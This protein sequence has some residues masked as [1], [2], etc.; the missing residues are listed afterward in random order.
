MKIKLFGFLKT[1]RQGIALISVLGL[2]TLATI[3]IMA[4]F[5]VSDAEFKASK[6]YADGNQARQF[7]DMAVN[8][9]TSQIQSAATGAGTGLSP[10]IWA[11]QPGAVRVY[12]SAGGFVRGRKLYSSDQMVVTTGGVVGETLMA[13][14]FPPSTWNEQS[15]EWANLNPTITSVNS[16]APG[17]AVS[18]YYPIIDPA[19]SV[20]ANGNLPVEGFSYTAAGASGGSLSGVTYPTGGAPASLPMPVKWLYVL[21]DGSVGTVTQAP[22]SPAASWTP[23]GAVVPTEDNPIIGRV[24]FWT[25][26]E[27]CKIN[28]NTAGEPSYYSVPTFF[29]EREAGWASRPPATFEYQRFP[30]HPATI[31]LSSVLYPNPTHAP[32][33]YNGDS[34]PLYLPAYLQLKNAIYNLTPKL[35]MGGSQD[36]TL[37]FDVDDFQSSKTDDYTVLARN[38]IESMREH[39]YTSVDEWIYDKIA[40]N[41]GRRQQVNISYGSGTELVDE[42]T[43]LRARP[44]LTAQSRA[45]E[46]NMF[47]LPR[48]AI[49]PVADESLGRN[50]RTG[51]DD[52]ITD[53][54][55]LGRRTAAVNPNSYIFRRRDSQSAIVDIGNSGIAS[56]GLQRNAELMNY[57]DKLLGATMPGG[58]SFNIKYGVQDSRQILVQIFDYIRCTNLYDAYLD[59]KYVTQ[60]GRDYLDDGIND[61]S[62]SFANGATKY[63]GS[64]L[65]RDVKLWNDTPKQGSYYTYTAPR[66]DT[67]RRVGDL[68]QQPENQQ[69]AN[70]FNKGNPEERVTVGAYP[71]HGQVRPIEWQ[72]GGMTYKGFGRFPTISEVALQFICTGDGYTGTQANPDPG[73]HQVTVNGNLIRSGGKTAQRLDPEIPWETGGQRH[74]LVDGRKPDGSPRYAYWYSNIPPYPSRDVFTKKWGCD[75]NAPESSLRHPRN[76][77][78]WDPANWNV[79]LEVDPIMG[80]IPLEEDEKR[81]QAAI[82]LELFIPSVGYTKIAP[83]FTIVLDG[84][85]LSGLQVQD[86]KGNWNSLFSTT[87]DLVVQSTPAYWGSRMG[88][89]LTTGNVSPMGGSYGSGPLMSGRQAKAIGPKMPKDPNYS[90]AASSDIHGAML[91][92]PLI[93]NPFT[94]KRGRNARIKFRVPNNPI[95]A[96]IYAS[97]DWQGT[98]DKKNATPVQSVMIQIPGA[99]SG[100]GNDGSHST[101]VPRLV[102]YSSDRRRVVS[103]GTLRETEAIHAVRWWAFNFAGAVGRYIGRP[104]PGGGPTGMNYTGITDKTVANDSDLGSGTWGRFHNQSRTVEG[105]YEEGRGQSQVPISTR[106]YGYSPYGPYTGVKAKEENLADEDVVTGSPDKVH[107]YGYWGSDSVRSIIPRHGDYRILAA[108]KVVPAGIWQLHP[109]WQVNPEALFAHS[110]TGASSD[111]EI[112]Y[113]PGLKRSPSGSSTTDIDVSL[114]LVPGAWYPTSQ[115]PDTPLTSTAAAQSASRRD[116]DNA[117]GAM[118]DGAYINKADDGN[119]SVAQFWYGTEKKFFQT[120]NAYFL[121]SFLQMPSKNAFFT[122]NRLLTGPGMFGS[123]PTG[124][125]GSRASGDS[126]PTVDGVPWRTLLFRPD[127]NGH[128]GALPPADHNILDL[129]WMPVVEP[130]AISDSFSTAGKV[131][132]NFQMVPFSH[133]TRATAMHAAMKGELITAVSAKDTNSLSAAKGPNNTLIYKT[134]QNSNTVPRTYW[135]ETQN[136]QWHRQININETIS[137]MKRRLNSAVGVPASQQGLFRTASQICEVHL[138]PNT[139]RGAEPPVVGLQGS[140]LTSTMNTFWNENSITGDNT[141]ERPYT[142]LYQKVTTRSNTFRVHFLAQTIRKARSLAPNQVDERFDNVTAEYRGS[143]LLERFLDFTNKTS[144]DYPNYGALPSPF[145][146][147]SLESQYRYRVLETK[148]FLP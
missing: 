60:R 138:I 49:W 57:L 11:S 136:R 92:Y 111:A 15:A 40:V 97:H 52:T 70:L 72:V 131:N 59:E 80:G 115:V 94:V 9:V 78:G 133:I 45:S 91:N 144:A 96:D 4:L 33:L 117:P 137:H 79:T 103:N 148:Q 90:D 122:P 123:L 25:D 139:T 86:A 28:I 43:I 105:S 27:S 75:F 48:V 77:P 13:N 125:F 85:K 113:D 2:V 102:V 127:V 88:E 82:Q 71:G 109:V 107:V 53:T 10:T 83:D 73:A 55:G 51:F 147:P 135:S 145:S 5:T 54:A 89:R 100:A 14:D 50:Y 120:R 140:A 69:L 68:T 108:K 37:A 126:N 119:L 3:L 61:G 56:V 101:P 87:G 6:V 104:Q 66:F 74:P 141:R 1:N 34:Y 124:V 146:A 20:A 128:V 36:G 42:K 31:A 143:S 99:S 17:A 110:L 116:F 65:Q 98:K 38:R 114:R 64:G 24:A 19:A 118:R 132:M 12:N 112:G 62:N 84:T 30:G 76:H 41:D 29:H 44:F 39:L 134:F 81:V 95:K 35:G 21:K 129:F 46:L 16:G 7:A 142:N 32:T 18:T 47:G 23:A 26:D 93:S 121:D 130:Y 63:A 67:V 8:L 106:I 22:G 58:G